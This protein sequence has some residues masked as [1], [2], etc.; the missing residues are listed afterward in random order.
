MTQ[1]VSA[2]GCLGQLRKGRQSVR[3]SE[4]MCTDHADCGRGKGICY[5]ELG[6]LGNTVIINACIFVSIIVLK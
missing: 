4:C 6:L 1:P 5:L 2:I 3:N